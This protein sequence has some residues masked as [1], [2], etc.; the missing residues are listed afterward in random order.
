MA[1][2]RP[3]YRSAFIPR[4][5]VRCLESADVHA[6]LRPSGQYSADSSLLPNLARLHSARGGLG[7][8]AR[9]FHYHSSIAARGFS[10]F[11]VHPAMASLVRPS[12]PVVLTFS[13]DHV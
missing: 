3:D 9:W 13:H 8:D 12:R 7:S 11:T 10:D 6:G 4:S 5:H 1:P 2:Q